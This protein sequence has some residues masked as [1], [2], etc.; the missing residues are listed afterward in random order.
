MLKTGK[1]VKVSIHL[2]Q[3]QNIMASRS[4]PAFLT[5]SSNEG[6]REQRRALLAGHVGFT[7]YWIVDERDLRAI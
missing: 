3:G 5:F 7:F 6:Y 1:A 4:V 2:N